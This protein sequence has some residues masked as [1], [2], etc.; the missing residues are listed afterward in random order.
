MTP[1]GKVNAAIGAPTVHTWGRLRLQTNGGSLAEEK[2]ATHPK[3]RPLIR[4]FLGA[5]QTYLKPSNPQTF[6]TET[7]NEQAAIRLAELTQDA[8]DLGTDESSLAFFIQAFGQS[9][10]VALTTPDLFRSQDDAAGIADAGDNYNA[11]YTGKAESGTLTVQSTLSPVATVSAA[12]RDLCK[13]ELQDRSLTAWGHWLGD[14]ESLHEPWNWCKTGGGTWNDMVNDARAGT[15]TI[16]T[17]THFITGS[18][19]GNLTLDAWITRAEARTATFAPDHDTNWSTGANAST[20][21]SKEMVR[22]RMEAATSQYTRMTKGIWSSDAFYSGT[23]YY[24]YEMNLV[25]NASF[26]ITTFGGGGSGNVDHVVEFFGLD[27]SSPILYP[28]NTSAGA[29][30]TTLARF[31][32]STARFGTGRLYDERRMF[33]NARRTLTAIAQ[34]TGP[35]PVFP[36]IRGSDTRVSATDTI[37]PNPTIADLTAMLRLCASYDNCLDVIFWYNDN[38]AQ[39]TPD[40]DVHLAA[41]EAFYP[42]YVWNGKFWEAA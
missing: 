33:N 24:N 29:L 42:E 18:S 20:G 40:H 39:A 6:T 38:P 37:N 35:S 2:L 19:P 21:S 16:V 22:L 1:S 4:T 14:T 11:I 8:V 26:P 7:R 23:L 36:W 25:D 5:D 12:L 13:A 9:T 27:G 28:Y 10:G 31:G 17:G 3:V 34:S 32:P 41:V 15:E 30:D